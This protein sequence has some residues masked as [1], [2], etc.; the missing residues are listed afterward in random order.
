M[1][2]FPLSMWK[3]E[4][5]IFM[6]KSYSDSRIIPLLDLKVLS[7]ENLG[8]SKVISI[9]RFKDVVLDTILL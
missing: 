8:E 9:D 5:C 2:S 3:S 4:L 6:Y 7:S 1:F